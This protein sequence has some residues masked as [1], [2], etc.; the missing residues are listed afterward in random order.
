M[1]KTRYL[2]PY[3]YKMVNGEI[4]VNEEEAVIVIF[5]FTEY[6]RGKSLKSI[7]D[8]LTER[9][10]TY[11]EGKETWNKSRIAR[12]IDNTKYIGDDGYPQIVLKELFW[13]AYEQRELKR[14]EISKEQT[15]LVDSIKNKIRCC[16]CGN[17]VEFVTVNKKPIE[18]NI[19]CVRKE[20]NYNTSIMEEVLISGVVGII[21]RILKSHVLLKPKQ[22]NIFH[23]T[24]TICKAEQSFALEIAN[25]YPNVE[26]VFRN[27]NVYA[28]SIYK[29][30]MIRDDIKV[31]ILCEKLTRLSQR[32]EFT[33]EAFELITENIKVEECKVMLTTK[34]GRCIE[35]VENGNQ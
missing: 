34:T 10:I 19:R 6:A 27:L 9:R 24:E 8:D 30:M 20:C 14:I 11:I 23:R 17:Q 25:D 26:E 15:N 12:L 29:E 5:I 31:K 35:G 2:M 4:V 18:W 32:R 22:R 3:G 33:I 13:K 1:K 21:N 28:S 16:R 7:A